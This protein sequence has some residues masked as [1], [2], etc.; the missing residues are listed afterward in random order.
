MLDWLYLCGVTLSE[1]ITLL[2][3]HSVIQSV[4][5]KVRASGK[6]GEKQVWNS[7]RYSLNSSPVMFS[8]F[9]APRHEEMRAVILRS[10]A[11]QAGAEQ[12]GIKISTTVGC[13]WQITCCTPWVWQW[14][15]W[16]CFTVTHQ[17]VMWGRRRRVCHLHVVKHKSWRWNTCSLK[18]LPSDR[19]GIQNLSST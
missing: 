8:W 18:A 1:N 16:I 12:T 15:R 14:T 9:F 17:T 6:S 11:L 13:S 7:E 2:L 5:K 3:I 10:H 19:F 4:T